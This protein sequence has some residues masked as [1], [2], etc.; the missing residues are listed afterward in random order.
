MFKFLTDPFYHGL[1]CKQN[2]WHLSNQWNNSTSSISLKIPSLLSIAAKISAL[3]LILPFSTHSTLRRTLFPSHLVW[4]S[5][6]LLLVTAKCTGQCPPLDDGLQEKTG[7]R[8]RNHEIIGTRAALHPALLGQC[9]VLLCTVDTP[10]SE[11]ITRSPNCMVNELSY[12][13]SAFFL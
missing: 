2:H 5:T 10:W 7:S 1:F 4:Y 3:G 8:A 11:S 9:I 13:W 12:S 6:N